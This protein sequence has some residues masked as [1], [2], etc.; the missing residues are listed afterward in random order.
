LN[1]NSSTLTVSFVPTSNWRAGGYLIVLFLFFGLGQAQA[2]V[3]LVQHKSIDAGTTSSATLTFTSNNIAGNWIGVCIRAGNSGETFTVTDSKGNTY[4]RAIQ[5]NET[6]NGNTLGVFY[7]ENIAGGGNTI[8]VSVTTATALRFAI[9]EYSGLAVSGS[10]DATVGTQGNSTSP[11]SGSVATTANGDLLLG[12]ILTGGTATFTAGSG[13]TTEESVP[14][15]P[16]T[17]LIAEDQVQTSAGTSSASASIAAS[18]NWAAVLAAFSVVSQPARIAFVQVNSAT[19]QPPQTSVAVPYDLAQT[20]GNLNVVVVGWNDSTATVSSVVDSKGNTYSLAIGPTVQTGVATQS[21]YY[22]KNIA[23]AAANANT[24]T[25]TF[26]SSA[27]YPDIRI[28]EYSGVDTVNPLDVSVA[29]QGNSLTSNSGTVTT[30]SANDLLVGANLVQTTTTGPGA[31]YL[32]RVITSQDADILEDRVVTTTGS[33]G[34]TAPVSSS[35]E[36]IMQMVAFR[37]AAGNG[38]GGAPSIT[39]LNPTSGGPGTSVTVAGTNFGGSQGTSTVTFNG[40]AGTPASWGATSIVVPVPSGAT[41]GNVVVT[42]GGVASNG[43]AFTVIPAPTITSFTPA[44]A[45]I[46]TL[47]SVTGTNFTANNATPSVTLNQQGGGTIPAPIS[48]F[49]ATNVSFVIPTGAATGFITVTANGLNAVS[50]TSLTITAASSFTLNATP[51]TATL[52]PGQTT[53][54]EV[55]LTSTNGFTQLASLAVSGLPS[56]VTAAFQPLQITPGQ[57]SFLTLTAPS[58]QA[59]G[60]SGLTITGTA[61]VQGIA[62]TSS[63]NVTLQVQ[64][65]SGVAFA[66]RVAVTDS[67]DT[68]LVGLTVKML[69][70][71]QTGVSTGCTGSKTTDGSGNFVLNGLSAS[72]AGGQLIQYDPSTVTSPAGTY[73]GVTLSYSLTSGQVTTPG[74]I[75]HLPRVDNAETFSVQNPA[76]VD[77]VFS[78]RSI[79]G[80]TITVYANTTL[81]LADGVTKPNPFPLSVVEIPYDRLPELMPPNPTQDPVFAMSI[82][83]FNSSANQPVAVSFPNRSKLPPGT[84]MPLTSLNPTMGIMQNYGTG[85]VSA[86]GTQVVPDLDSAHPGH[87]YGISHFDWH[88]SLPGANAV[89]PG[90]GGLK[91]GDPIDLA[92]GLPVVTKTDIVLGGARGQ[93]AI[94]RIFRGATTNAGPFGIGTNHNYGYLLDT[95]NVSGGL[96]NLILPDGNQIPFVQSGGMWGN[97]TI[98]STQGAV[99]SN[100]SCAFGFGS[101]SACSATLRWKDGTTY[102][103]QPFPLQ[104]ATVSFLTSITDANGNK[105]TV[106]RNQNS[107]ISQIIDPVGRSL[108]FTYDSNRPPRILSVSDQ[109]GRTVQ[110]TYNP[111]GYLATVTDANTPAGVTTYGYDANNNLKTITDARNITYL[112]NTYDPNG[113]VIQQQTIDGGVTKFAYAQANPTISTSPVLLTTVTD[114]LNNQTTYHFNPAGFVLDVT[115]ALGRKTVFTRDGGTNLLLSVTDPLGRATTFT[116]DSN[117]NPLTVR[118]L[119]GTSNAVTATLTYDPVFNKLASI[120]DPLGLGHTTT[121]GYD[122]AGNLTQVT[123]PIDPPANLGYDGAGELTSITDPLSNPPTQIVYDG[124]GNVTQSVDPLGRKFSRISDAVGRAQSLANALGQTAQFQYGPLNQVTQI[125]DPLNGKTSLTYDPNGNLLTLTDALGTTHTT[126]YTYD[127]MDRLATRKDPLG[128]S[129]SYQYDL[130]GNLFQFTDR[131]GKIATFKY[132]AVNRRIFA[133]FGTTAGPPYESTITYS[134]DAGDRLIQAVDSVTGTITRSYDGLNRLISEAS[135]R[136]SVSYS[137]DAAGRRASMTVGGQSAVTYSFDNAN[138]LKQITQGSTSV[139]FNYDGDGRRFSTTLPNGVSMNYGYDAASQ[140]ASITY[141]NGSTTIGSLTYAYDLAGRR[142]GVGGSYARTNAPQAAS[143]ASFNVNNQLTQWKGASLT[144]DA[145][146]NLTS[147]GTNTYTW[148]ARNQLVSISGGVAASFQYDPFGRRVSKTIG[149]TTQYLY[150]GVNSVQEISGTSAS[151]NLLTGDVDEYFQRTDSA[152]ARNFL[153]DALGSTLALTDSSGTVQTSYTFEPFGNTI[154]TGAT[155]TNSFAYTGRE[156]DAAGLYY[157]RARY[158]NPSL[159]RFISEDPLGFGGGDANLYAY[160]GNGPTNFTDAIG[161]NRGCFTTAC[162]GVPGALPLSGRKPRHRGLPPGWYRCGANGIGVPGGEF[163]CDGHGHVYPAPLGNLNDPIFNGLLFSGLRVGVGIAEGVAEGIGSGIA[164]DGVEVT[165]GHGARH[166]LG[167]GL[168]Q[169]AVESAIE[170]QVQDIAAASTGG[171]G[172]FWG[173]VVVDGQTIFYRAFTLADGTINIG[174]YTVGVP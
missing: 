149:G 170:S 11:N 91:A 153:T 131:R 80:V 76:S 96:I 172:N 159:Q 94:T 127:N 21:I 58:G 160:V 38:G 150:D 130:D 8:T 44:S 92:S 105:T 109:I 64:G 81:T 62:Q 84:D 29:A 116:Y 99:L 32:S 68:P 125:T 121:F 126:T 43:V 4:H 167:S 9:F 89:N 52:L 54:Y 119:A 122:K 33:Y 111:A 49:S 135:P 101:G 147:D 129:E 63:A 26:T 28:A 141:K 97:T 152:G 48:S 106:V 30:T 50:S 79:P 100:L 75:V 5:F 139:A 128:N 73:S 16:N 53:T 151:A 165:F 157:Y 144:Y 74:I 168:S 173:T 108:S 107:T 114:P 171:T 6:G 163:A 104:L 124:F 19:P 137:Y 164:E 86:D 87:R 123:D 51:G 55:T 82:E 23:A 59:P 110:Y 90:L 142:A 156:L 169:D 132:D 162:G 12:A 47:I 115:D 154:V 102:Q 27:T 41:T 17:K 69:G 103:F 113:R 140:L 77:Q 7:A 143:T 136:G 60:A 24:V 72:C 78:S 133:G 1:L 56:G 45:S 40:T 65:T 15:E 155:T 98:F 71:N 138:H 70:V 67:Y 148:N 117:G 83:P 18:D 31:N 118:R 10:L 145:N 66:G 20:A 14:S 161:M 88:F 2:S 35:S 57:F 25:V 158:Y 146:G 39:G 85:A 61:T 42:V 134:Y 22:A 34:A 3:A 13:Y 37:A 46:G 95:T 93:I 120:T 166:L 112:T 174:T 36:W